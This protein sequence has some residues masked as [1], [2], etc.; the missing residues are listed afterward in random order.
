MTASVYT[1]SQRASIIQY[2]YFVFDCH[3]HWHT[4]TRYDKLRIDSSSSM[5]STFLF[6]MKECIELISM[7]L[8]FGVR[9]SYT[10][11]LVVLIYIVSRI[12]HLANGTMFSIR[13]CAIHAVCTCIFRVCTMYA[14][15]D[16]IT[17]DE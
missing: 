14:V 3:W 16:T 13:V 7:P 11:L 12:I 15:R 10:H 1:Y 5:V 9:Y 4:D 2:I 6:A 17:I 8:A